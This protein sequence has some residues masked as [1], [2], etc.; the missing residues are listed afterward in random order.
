MI[1]SKNKSNKPC[2]N[3]SIILVLC[4]LTNSIITYSQTDSFANKNYIVDFEKNQFDYLGI[5]SLNQKQG[6]WGV[7]T[8]VLLLIER[9]TGIVLNCKEFG[10][11][12]DDKKEG[13]WNVYL[14]KDGSEIISHRF[15]MQ[16]ELLYEVQYYNKKPIAIVRRKTISRKNNQGETSINFVFDEIRFNKNGELEYREH[17]TPDGL[18]QKDYYNR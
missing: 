15:Y 17:V 18:I 6:Y 14:T 13:I 10:Y 3:V 12:F 9:D 4:F 1:T 5:D 16:D 2:F 7:D 11:Y 8:E